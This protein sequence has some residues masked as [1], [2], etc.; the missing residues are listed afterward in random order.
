[1]A[2]E[3]QVVDESGEVVENPDLE[4]GYI[5]NNYLDTDGKGMLVL[6]KRIYH[7]YTPEQLEQVQKDKQAQQ[8]NEQSTA[9]FLDGG[10]SKMEQDIKDAS[11]ASVNE[12][13]DALLGLDATDETEATD[14][15]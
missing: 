14:A 15:E 8:L 11:A 9:F 6:Q 12:Y 10:K 4:A 7:L 13:L 1:M 5:E 2:E 3:M